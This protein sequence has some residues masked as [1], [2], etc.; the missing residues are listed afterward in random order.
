MCECIFNVSPYPPFLRSQEK[1]VT[2]I[3]LK[4]NSQ[5]ILPYLQSSC[6]ALLD[7]LDWFSDFYILWWGIL[8]CRAF[9]NWGVYIRIIWASFLGSPDAIDETILFIINWEEFLEIS[10]TRISDT[11]NTYTDTK[12]THKPTLNYYNNL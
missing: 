6:S 8:W 5:I 1:E 2:N 12:R 9:L 7:V 10:S 11:V 4:L 3:L